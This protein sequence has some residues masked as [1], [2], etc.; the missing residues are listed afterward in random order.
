MSRMHISN[1]HTTG[2]RVLHSFARDYC[3]EAS[4]DRYVYTNRC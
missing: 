1:T 3:V 2:G 4:F